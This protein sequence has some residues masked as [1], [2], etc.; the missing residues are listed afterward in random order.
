MADLIRAREFSAEAGVW[1]RILRLQTAVPGARAVDF[2][3]AAAERERFKLKSRFVARWRGFGVMQAARTGAAK[4]Q[5][6]AISRDALFYFPIGLLCL[7][8][9]GMFRA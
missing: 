5:G 8:K 3:S 1:L 2:D 4:K 9:P 7:T 6:V